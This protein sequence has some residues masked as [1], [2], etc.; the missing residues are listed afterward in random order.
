MPRRPTLYK[1]VSFALDSASRNHNRY[2][3]ATGNSRNG[4]DAGVDGTHLGAH[5][6]ITQ[7]SSFDLTSKRELKF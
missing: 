5:G 6:K 2:Q 7:L 1:A 4:E 3:P